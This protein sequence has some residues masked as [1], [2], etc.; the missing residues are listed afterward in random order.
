M[1]SRVFGAQHLECDRNLEIEID[2]LVHPREGAGSE[3]SCYTVFAES[4]AEI[5]IG[6]GAAFTGWSFTGALKWD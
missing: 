1:L 2:G 4:S 5:A 3:E 6:Q